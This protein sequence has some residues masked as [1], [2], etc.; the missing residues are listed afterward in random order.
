[1]SG[2]GEEIEESEKESANEAEVWSMP[3]MLGRRRIGMDVNESGG[4]D[5][6]RGRKTN[7]EKLRMEGQRHAAFSSLEV[8]RMTS[9]GS[10]VETGGE[11]RRKRERE[12]QGEEVGGGLRDIFRRSKKTKRTPEKGEKEKIELQDLAVLISGL[13]GEML[14]KLEAVQRQGSETKSEVESMRVKLG[15]WENAWI[16][17]SRELWEKIESM[18]VRAV[19]REEERKGEMR[20]ME[21]RMRA[22]EEEVE[23][24]L[25]MF[26]VRGDVEETRR[27]GNDAGRG[28]GVIVWA[29]LASVE[30]KREVM[31]G[32]RELRGRQERIDG[33]LTWD[34]RRMRWMMEKR[35]RKEREK[36]NMVRNRGE[37][38]W[39]NG[40]EWRWDWES[41]DLVKLE[42][43]L[44]EV[45]R[46]NLRRTRRSEGVENAT[47]KMALELSEEKKKSG[48]WEDECVEAKKS[49][50]AKTKEWR[51]GVVGKDEWNEER[52]KF[53]S[54]L[55]AKK[56]EER[57]RYE[58]EVEEAV[59]EGREWEVVNRETKRKK[60]GT[61]WRS[62]SKG[63]GTWKEESGS[64]EC[65]RAEYGRSVVRKL[66]MGKSSAVDELENEV[67]KW[68]GGKVTRA[69][70]KPVI[71][72][73]GRAD[74]EKEER[75][76]IL[77]FEQYVKEKDLVV[78]VRKTK[79]MECGKRK[80]TWMVER[81][82]RMN[83]Q[84]VNEVQKNGSY[85]GEVYEVGIW[86]EQ[87]MSRL[88]GEG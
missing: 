38:V 31:L 86:S 65:W 21:E 45:Q 78:N 76:V 75:R 69:I 70:W 51:E 29:R 84:E 30:M 47:M 79:M 35:V 57:K 40:E 20:R 19:M 54:M 80:R 43:G 63:G 15:E 83:G 5:G 53:Q 72:G 24:L 85:G 64:G 32:K 46:G 8:W 62:G 27:I 88:Y 25:G 13:K 17:D 61:A 4:M 11:E 73:F 77:E 71:V 16:E 58:Q 10:E 42:G 82:W 26:G 81:L 66:K 36:G 49:V 7:V 18:E 1:M 56:E 52:K 22:L 50:K 2:R 60:G 68:G 48:W 55:K 9:S 67:F 59:R 37:Q 87:A 34:E 44:Q 41:D 12:Q 33:D 28:S 14:A 3:K 39:V 6:W 23:R 74:A